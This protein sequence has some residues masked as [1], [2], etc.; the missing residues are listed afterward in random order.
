MHQRLHRAGMRAKNQITTLASARR[1][2][3]LP[4][5]RP[6]LSGGG[7]LVPWHTPLPREGGLVVLAVGVFENGGRIAGD[8][9]AVAM[10]G[11]WT[12]GW[13]SKRGGWC[14]LTRRNR[15][16]LSDLA[17]LQRAVCQRHVAEF[18]P[19]AQRDE[20]IGEPEL[21]PLAG[22]HNLV[23]SARGSAGSRGQVLP[24][25]HAEG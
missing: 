25:R 9:A 18:Q 21:D 22:V 11:G 14:P 17:L 20:T 23:E 8:G 19:R 24:L 16:C 15:R 5:A 4:P 12:F 10:G 3:P 7:G 6:L 1:M 2:S 13:R